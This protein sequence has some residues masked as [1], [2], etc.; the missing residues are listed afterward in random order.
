MQRSLDN[1]RKLQELL[2]QAAMRY[3]KALK[4]DRTAKTQKVKK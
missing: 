1:G 3:A 2:H 4:H